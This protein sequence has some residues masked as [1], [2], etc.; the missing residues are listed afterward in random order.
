MAMLIPLFI[1]E[2]FK[3]RIREDSILQLVDTERA[4][5]N[6][7]P[8]QKANTILLIVFIL[9]SFKT[10]CDLTVNK[11]VIKMVVR[12]LSDKIDTMSA[13]STTMVWIFIQKIITL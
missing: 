6:T 12:H 9:V 10:F 2:P 4:V 3:F 8:C 1:K 5:S 11:L 7:A 13:S